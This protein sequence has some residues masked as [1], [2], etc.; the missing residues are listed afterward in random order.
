M[1]ELKRLTEKQFL[2]FK[3]ECE[4]WI[5]Y[6]GLKSCSIEICKSE[7]KKDEC[8]AYTTR[9]RPTSN[10]IYAIFLT[11]WQDKI[12]YPTDYR[13]RETAYHEV[14]EV[15]MYDIS[16][17]IGNAEGNFNASN[18]VHEV[19]RTLENTMFKDSYNKRFNRSR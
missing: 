16:D 12:N 3:K 1:S 14:L 6:L 4:Y 17:L 7:D 18:N 13:L 10:R 9:T 19:I 8:R 15:M 2:T 11:M 5:D